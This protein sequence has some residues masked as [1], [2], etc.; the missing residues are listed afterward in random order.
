MPKVELPAIV[1]ALALSIFPLRIAA[2]DPPVFDIVIYGGTS[3]AVSD[4]FGQCRASAKGIR[5]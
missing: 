2:D 5:R 4:V 3:A 1:L